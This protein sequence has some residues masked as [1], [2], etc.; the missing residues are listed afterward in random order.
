LATSAMMPGFQDRRQQ[1]TIASLAVRRLHRHLSHLVP[2]GPGQHCSATAGAAAGALHGVPAGPMAV[3][4]IEVRTVGPEVARFRWDDTLPEF[5]C[6][7][8]V[9]RIRTTCG[10]E[11]VGGISNCQV[12]P[13]VVKRP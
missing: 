13:G 12:P 5:F 1:P 6:T 7:N 8:T 9:V 10:L 11:G 3:A 4:S 2:G